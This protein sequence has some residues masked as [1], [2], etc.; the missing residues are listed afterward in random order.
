MGVTAVVSD[1]VETAGIATSYGLSFLD[2]WTLAADA[3]V[4]E[5]LKTAGMVLAGKTNVTQLGL[6]HLG[7]NPN[8]GNARNVRR[9]SN[10]VVPPLV[11]L[12]PQSTLQVDAPIGCLFHGSR[13]IL[14]AL[15]EGLQGAQQL[16]WLLGSANLQSS[17]TRVRTTTSDGLLRVVEAR[18][19]SGNCVVAPSCSYSGRCAYPCCAVWCGR[20][21]ADVRSVSPSRYFPAG[22][23]QGLDGIDS[24][25]SGRHAVLG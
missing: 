16:Q 20:I 9:R 22:A 4:V 8:F 2:E 6:S 12:R 3:P 25:H 23:D 5:R 10:S 21:Q 13:M 19:A 7:A 11:R 1:S 18:V 24:A 15:P 17:R 14:P